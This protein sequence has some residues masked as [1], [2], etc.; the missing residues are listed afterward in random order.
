MD[1]AS[2]APGVVMDALIYL[3]VSWSSTPVASVVPPTTLFFL[4]FAS[5]VVTMATDDPR[6]LQV[7]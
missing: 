3:L 2:Q 4:S 7:G 6:F 1:E 5:V